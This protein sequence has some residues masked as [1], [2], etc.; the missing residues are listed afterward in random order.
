MTIFLIVLSLISDIS[1]AV[2][3]FSDAE[4][5]RRLLIFAMFHSIAS[6]SAA[7]AMYMLLPT[8]VRVAQSPYIA[9]GFMFMMCMF[10][11]VVGFIG[12]F[13]CVVVAMNLPRKKSEV[14]WVHNPREELPSHPRDMMYTKFGTGALQDILL[15]APDTERR[16]EAIS[17]VSHLP[18]DQRISFYK[19]ALRDPA[20]DVRLMAYSQL[21]PIEQ[22]ITDN[23]KMLED[24]FKEN[25]SADIAYDI[26]QQFWEICYLGI[27]DTVLVK[28]YLNNARKWC[29]KAIELEDRGNFELL[30][31]R[32]L[33]ELN[34]IEPAMIALQKA[35]NAKML[36][37]QV[38]TYLAEC[39]FRMRDYVSVK[40]YL[41][42]L[43]TTE[44]SKLSQIREYWL[45][46][47]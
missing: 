7:Y 42:S 26:A 19:I 38:N 31:G 44:G 1:A 13:V 17:S 43:Y 27:A 22:G 10:L 16:V 46:A 9:V 2:Y 12:L 45:N 14:M 28:H 33:L 35:K 3:A 20:D 36:D 39:A 15:N 41:S 47:K 6:M 30:L 21:D 29:Q 34:E 24:S 8:N 23:I 32:I 11:P 25:N 5:Y 18:R 37:S 40:S 4:L